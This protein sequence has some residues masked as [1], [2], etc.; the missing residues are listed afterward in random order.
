MSIL[1]QDSRVAY[2]GVWLAEV[3]RSQK[4]EARIQNSEVRSQKSEVRMKVRASRGCSGLSTARPRGR[5]RSRLGKSRS[6]A[7]LGMTRGRRQ[8]GTV[9]HAIFPAGRRRVTLAKKNSEARSQKPGVR[10]QKSEA[11]SQKS[12][13]RSQ[14]SEV[15]SQKSE[16]G[17]QKPE[18]RMK[19]RASR[20][21]SG[22]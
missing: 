11:R 15:R 13:V 16:V 21:C 2:A 5:P 14:K 6:L 3:A 19:V 8:V 22:L 12:E 17:S 7:V 10:S 4:P 9:S 1:Y 20:G 18:V